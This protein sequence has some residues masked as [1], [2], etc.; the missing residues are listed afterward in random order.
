[1]EPHGA[2]GMAAAAAAVKPQRPKGSVLGQAKCKSS[3]MPL[4]ASK[5]AS[6]RPGMSEK[7][8]HPSRSHP[9]KDHPTLLCKE[10]VPREL[11][12]HAPPPPARGRDMV[13]GVRL[14]QPR[15][16]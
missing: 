6:R 2:H 5:S 12:H 16:V 3:V 15:Q 10:T 8:R 14:R 13:I 11:P 9:H 7:G 4:S 1:M